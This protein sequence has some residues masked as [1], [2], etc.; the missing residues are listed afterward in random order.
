MEAGAKMGR[1]TL[2]QA[3]AGASSGKPERM[4]MVCFLVEEM[5]CDVNEM[6]MPED[7]RYP[8]HFGTPISYAAYWG[9]TDEVV[10]YLLEVSLAM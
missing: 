3:V 6:D 9:G 7:K 5:G 4:E 2:H 10:K 1:R 8:L